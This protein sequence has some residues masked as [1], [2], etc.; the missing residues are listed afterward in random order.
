LDNESLTGAEVG[1][2]LIAA[3]VDL[4]AKKPSA[5]VI[6]HAWL[7]TQ[8]GVKF[9]ARA[10]A[11][12]VS[13]ILCSPRAGDFSRRRMFPTEVFCCGPASVLVPYAPPGLKLA[14][15]IRAGTE[16]FLQ[17]WQKPPQVIL[18]QNQGIITLGP[19]WQSVLAAMLMAE[20]AARIFLGATALGGP[21]FLSPE[22]VAAL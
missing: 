7:L 18:I 15:A 21:V 6:A 10:H 9:V 22:E 17:Q 8:P 14:R 12:A 16:A 11:T 1:D 19:T 4:K 13:Q 2:A 5:E 20:K 3:R